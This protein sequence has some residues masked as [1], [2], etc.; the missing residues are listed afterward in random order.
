MSENQTKGKGFI[1][2]NWQKRRRVLYITLAF[3]AAT[4]YYCIH[5]DNPMKTHEIATEFSFI[6]IIILVLG[7]MGWAVVDDNNVT[8]TLLSRGRNKS[9]F[10]RSLRSE[11]DYD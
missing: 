1:E 7:Y 4:I 5:V 10:G 11:S 6:G 2:H 8:K 3:F 9:R